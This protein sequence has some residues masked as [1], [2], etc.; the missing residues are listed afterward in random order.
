MS[1]IV[2]FYFIKSYY[3]W[4][5]RCSSV[6]EHLPSMHRTWI[7]LLITTQKSYYSLFNS[8]E[9]HDIPWL[10]SHNNVVWGGITGAIQ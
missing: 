2:I 5:W 7:L 1:I 6:V 10:I 4:G 3:S 9:F 8:V